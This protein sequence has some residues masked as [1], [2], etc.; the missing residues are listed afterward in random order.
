MALDPDLVAAVG[1]RTGAVVD[2][3]WLEWAYAEVM[4]T[5]RLSAP[6]KRATWLAYADL[7]A[8][9]Q[10]AVVSSLSRMSQNPRGIRQETIGEYSYTLTA[11]NGPGGPFTSTEARII[12]ALAGCGGSVKSVPFTSPDVLVLDAPEANGL[13]EWQGVLSE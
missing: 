9:V 7:P 4:A 5:I 13:G 2:E 3:A 6:C 11:S 1:D 10:A 12:A 8:D